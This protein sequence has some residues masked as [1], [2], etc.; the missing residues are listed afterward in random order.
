MLDRIAGCA[1]APEVRGR[2]MAAMIL[3][4]MGWLIASDTRAAVVISEAL[5]FEDAANLDP[6]RTHEWIEI[7]NSG[8]GAV[9][10][11]GW[12]IADR[13][14]DI[15]A[16]ARTL[17]A[18]ILPDGAY[19]LVHISAGSDDLDFGDGCGELYTGD[20][21]GVNLYSETN[22]ELALYSTTAIQDLLAWNQGESGYVAGTA[23][24]DAVGAGQ[25]T[26]GEFVDGDY[27]A[28]ARREKF[29]FVEIGNSI[30]RDMDA[31]D[32]DE[33]G[34]WDTPGGVDGLDNS[35]CRQNLDLLDFEE[36]TS[37]SMVQIF[38][39]GNPTPSTLSGHNLSS[40]PTDLTLTPDGTKAVVRAGATGDA[41]T[42]YEL[43]TGTKL[44]SIG[45]NS[46]PS[47]T[48]DSVEATDTRAVTLGAAGATDSVHIV[49]LSVN[50]PATLNTFGL[51]SAPRD[52]AITPDGTK[53]VVRAGGSPGGITVYDLAAAT[54]LVAITSNSGP[55]ALDSVEVTD[56][57]AVT[58]G[59]AGTTDSVQILDLTGGTPSTL[60]SFNLNS[61]PVGLAI[62]PDGSKAVVRAGGSTSGITVYDLA[63]GTQLTSITSNSAPG[64]RNPVEVTDTRAVL[65][66]A[67]GVTDSVHIL[68]LTTNP[69]SSMAT[70]SLISSPSDLAI[71]PDGTKAVVRAGGTPDAITVYDLTLGTQIATIGSNSAPVY[72]MDAVQVTDTRAITVGAVGATDSVH[73]LDLTANPPVTVNTFS[74]NSAPADIAITSDG[75]QAIV[76]SGATPDAVTVYDLAAGTQLGQFGSRFLATGEQDSVQATDLRAVTISRGGEIKDWTIMV[77]MCGDDDVLESSAF[78]DLNEMEI[79]GGSDQNVNVVVQVDGLDRIRQIGQPATQGKTFRFQV[80]AD[81]NPNIVRMYSVAGQDPFLG[82]VNMGVPASL[83]SFM[84]WA[85][86]NHPA[87]KY[88]LILWGH[89]GGWKG[90]CW[91]QTFSGFFENEDGLFMNEIDSVVSLFNLE[92]LGFDESF[93][94]GVEVAYEFRLS[95]DYMVASQ[96]YEPGDGWPYELWL[97]ELKKFSETW[98]GAELGTQIVNDYDYDWLLRGFTGRTLSAI[99]LGKIG[100]LVSKISFFANDL[101]LAADDFQVHDIQNDNIEERI[102]L[103]R[104]ATDTYE[105]QNYIDLFDFTKKLD[106]D[107]GIPFCWRNENSS[108]RLGILDAVIANE[109]GPRHR[110]NPMDPTSHGLSIYFPE[111]RT[112][113][114]FAGLFLNLVQDSYDFPD[115]SR[116]TDGNSEG[117]QYAPNNDMLP[118]AQ[119]D[120]EI[121]GQPHIT[122]PADT[123]RFPAELF[124]FPTDSTWD[125]FLMRFYHPVA[126]NR[127]RHAIGPNGEVAFPVVSEMD[128]DDCMNPVD[129]I[130]VGQDWTVFFSGRGSTDA[131]SLLPALDARAWMWDFDDNVATCTGPFQAPYGVPDG[132]DPAILACNDME[133]DQSLGAAS[134]D[135]ADA[136]T[137]LSSNTY[138]TIGTF[139]VNL[140]AWDYNDLF[141]LHDTLPTAAHVH[142]QTDNHTS[143]VIVEADPPPAFP[144]GWDFS[145]TALGGGI[146][147]TI[148]GAGEQCVINVPTTPGQSAADV[149]AAVAAAMEL[150]PCVLGRG[151]YV[152]AVG[153]TVFVDGDGL[154]ESDVSVNVFDPGLIHCGCG[155]GILE[156]ACGEQCDDGNNANGDCCS[157]S[158]DFE[159]SGSICSE[160]TACVSGGTCDGTG[161]CTSGTPFTCPDEGDPCTDHFCTPGIGCGT[162]NNTAPCEDGNLCTLNDTCSAGICLPG[163]T[164]PCNDLVACTNDTCVA[165]SCQFVP[166]GG[167]ETAQ[168]MPASSPWSSL[169]TILLMLGVGVWAFSRRIGG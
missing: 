99:D 128:L 80:G 6:L 154:N 24:G 111:S 119:E 97:P 1:C 85:V 35:P 32:T 83:N 100:G 66:G 102:R 156:P 40:Q 2:L 115:Y 121:G 76:R 137:V 143:V 92:L 57:R 73:I 59:A 69:P 139:T 122:V 44:V 147:I 48:T 162:S 60:N 133:A 163:S 72:G 12:V 153:D 127:I 98:T 17:P 165:G 144:P 101:R 13:D 96:E 58:L 10:L 79:A 138:F 21:A 151:I 54:Q 87:D 37:G 95:A 152:V 74:L 26:S 105:D 75:T 141:E 149:A 18:V 116:L 124:D 117:A 114:V 51:S 77:Y 70:F 36:V 67:A 109:V 39:V 110:N 126:D 42:V 91:D 158:C 159:L 15:G 22:Q 45:S 9:D 29:R 135:E 47:G 41:I 169:V 113:P 78:D 157:G 71:T 25:W 68:D 23:H 103:A 34:D 56:S 168:D 112:E 120:A 61:A 150:D 161:S 89:G 125:E 14:G 166:I 3:V 8:P 148:D 20:G 50:P 11:T 123:P 27:I 160:E 62:T 46:A 134:D 108:I 82:E 16:A 81:N 131:D 90:T 136:K 130:T 164:M 104:N 53:A 5:Y 38:V 28:R 49:D 86:T 155:N 142:I 4:L 140:N 146:E 30:G 107:F 84:T 33:I 7:H 52:L 106:D 132:S 63:A 64:A 88:G 43:A 93:M 19:L 65:L 94:A 129:T 55:A 31:Q 167:C 145:G 118:M